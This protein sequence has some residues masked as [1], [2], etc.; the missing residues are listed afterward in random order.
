MR[1]FS[2]DRKPRAKLRVVR[3]SLLNLGAFARLYCIKGEKTRFAQ[4]AFR[5]HRSGD[6]G[7]PKHA[8]SPLAFVA[9]GEGGCRSVEP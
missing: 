1:Y 5:S 2:V 8:L 7:V 9:A 4:T 3:A 6:L